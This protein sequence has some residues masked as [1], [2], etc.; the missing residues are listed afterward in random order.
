MMKK[1][2]LMSRKYK[3][4]AEFSMES[5]FGCGI[6]ACWGCVIR[7]KKDGNEKWVKACSEGPVFSGE[8][9]IW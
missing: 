7:V 8:E 9:I 3:I 2:A 4:K 1:I 6:G 5:V